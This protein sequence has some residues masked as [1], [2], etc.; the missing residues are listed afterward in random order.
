[1]IDI[2]NIK[3]R[4][5]YK[6]NLYEQNEYTLTDTYHLNGNIIP[7]V[8]YFLWFGS[9]LPRW[10]KYAIDAYRKMNPEFNIKVY[11]RKQ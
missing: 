2:S 6:L 8:L 11:K 5:K 4:T 9:E 7:C 3:P 1:M 10:A